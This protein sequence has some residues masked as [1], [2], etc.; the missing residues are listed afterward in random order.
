MSEVIGVM[1]CIKDIT[2]F[3]QSLSSPEQRLI[4]VFTSKTFQKVITG[5]FQTPLN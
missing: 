3:F 4:L 5:V 1:L 2:A